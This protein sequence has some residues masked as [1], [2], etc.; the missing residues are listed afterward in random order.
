MAPHQPKT[1]EEL[2]DQIINDILSNL[3]DGVGL[4]QIDR[5][6]INEYLKNADANKSGDFAAYHYIHAL[7]HTIKCEYNLAETKYKTALRL[8][9]NN[10]PML[11][12]YATLLVDA[13]SYE[14]AFNIAQKLINDFRVTDRITYNIIYNLMLRTLNIK[15]F[16]P[17]LEN[18][19]V[20][21]YLKPV[22]AL[23]SLKDG[24][25]EVNISIDEYRNFMAFFCDFIW[26]ETRQ[27]FRP[28][29][30]IVNDSEEYLLIEVFLDVNSDEV[31]YL[32]SKFKEE[33]IDHIFDNNK[34]D[35]LGKFVVSFNQK[36]SRYDNTRNPDDLYLGTKQGLMI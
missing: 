18:R 14:E 3:Q 16:K 33:Y 15:Y 22:Y 12:N 26:K 2:L 30:T 32:D 7:I 4:F 28:R 8:S 34:Y 21:N 17:F 6:K 23:K 9:P 20:M 29:F 10:T 25:S 24:L 19:D 5:K 11:N 35:S 1:K 13:G 31:L 27:N 36:S